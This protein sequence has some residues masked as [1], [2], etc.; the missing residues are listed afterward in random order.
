MSLADADQLAAAL[1]RSAARHL[2]GR[3][4]IDRVRVLSGGA[5]AS[6][7]EFDATLDG[8]VQRLI[9]QLS[10]GEPFMG[11][12]R[13]TQQGLT[14]QLAFDSG[15]P[16][17]QVRWILDESDGLGDGYVSER[18][19][20]ETL[21]KRI[22]EDPAFAQ[23][24]VAMTAQCGSILARIHTL[25]IAA[26]GY[27]PMLDV[28]TLVARLSAQHRAYEERLPVFELAIRWLGQNVP[29]P[30]PASPLH[31]DFRTGNFIVDAQG[32]AAVL[33]WEMAHRGD[34]MEDLAW[35]CMNAW[36]FGRIDAPVG[37]FGARSE[38][39]SAY[40]RAGGS[41]VDEA[42]VRFWE[43]YGALKWGVI[44]Q[45]FAFGHLRGQFRAL[46]RASIGRRVAET[47]LDLLELMEG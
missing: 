20:G 13:K 40:E 15:I 39:Y 1:T 10:T 12:L 11:S 24:R 17:P 16:T 46:E 2:G 9:L 34:P 25:D 26:F 8:V 33:D 4:R 43:V 23:A 44:C 22:V 7:W 18:I 32:I 31:G 42:A 5:S 21:G 14:Q 36:R 41:P 3:V 45:H 29:A 6:T 47:E 38:L 30:R 28:E 19:A 35:L 27:L 37:G